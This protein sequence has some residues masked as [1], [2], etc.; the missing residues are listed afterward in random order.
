MKNF[1][2]KLGFITAVIFVSSCNENS[3]DIWYS[4]SWR[5][6]SELELILEN[7]SVDD[8]YFAFKSLEQPTNPGPYYNRFTPIRIQETVNLDSLRNRAFQN[9]LTANEIN[10]FDFS[11]PP[12]LDST[13][14]AII[15][16]GA[17]FFLPAK[18]ETKITFNVDNPSEQKADKYPVVFENLDFVGQRKKVLDDFYEKGN[19]GN[20]KPFKNPV[21][22]K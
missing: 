15:L 18:S 20:F 3:G 21:L 1:L 4:T 10:G 11:V 17:F 14:K 19:I 12:G 13:N 9:Y 5:N 8:Y 22:K 2:Y 16:S 6:D 7:S